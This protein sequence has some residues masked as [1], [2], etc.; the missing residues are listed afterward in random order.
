MTE[1]ELIDESIG[2]YQNACRDAD[3]L[4]TKADLLKRQAR[5][6]LDQAT[7]CCAAALEVD[8]RPSLRKLWLDLLNP[9]LTLDYFKTICGALLLIV[10]LILIFFSLS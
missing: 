7:A 6:S 2:K 5:E 9:T 3:R 1:E 8:P 10:I 4:Y